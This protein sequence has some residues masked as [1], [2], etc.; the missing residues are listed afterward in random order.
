[1]KVKKPVK[2]LVMLL[3]LLLVVEY[4]VL[5][6]IPGIRH[7]LSLIADANIWL[8][9][10]GVGL[11][12]IALSAYA[13]LT[14]T[15]LP[16]ETRPRFGRIVRIDLSTLSISHIVPGGGAV[17]AGLGYRLLT[18]A[19]VGG[20]DAGFALG[21]QGIGS[22]VVLNLLL[23][24]A[25]VV[26]I[27]LHGFNPVYVTAAAVGAVLIGAFALLVLALTRGEARAAKVFRA[28]ARKLP[29]LDE[30]KV[31]RMVHRLAARIRSLLRDRR[32]LL[33]A[34]GWAA[35]NW[36]FD[37]ASLWVFLA[38]YGT[39]PGPVELMVAYGLANVLAAIPVTPGGLGVVEAVLTATLVGF[40][41]T[42]GPAILGVITY[43]LVN[44]WL[45]IPVGGLCYV[46]LA[47]ERGRRGKLREVAQ[48]TIEERQRPGEWAAEHGLARPGPPQDAAAS[49]AG[50]R[51]S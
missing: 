35:A 11:E 45:P 40:G 12:A 1:M 39:P 3:L 50:T 36:I 30:E 24:L 38:A 49:D 10:A 26:S 5:P 2:R 25:L 22:A 17:G 20:T 8:I 14:R 47:V 51:A 18:E 33:R 34:I 28:V 43:R 15:V 9:L 29:F 32:L 13:Q 31:H 41:M 23:W 42:R 6:Q 21:T 37:A 16:V 7:S 4:L 27:P 48:Q 19:G 46:S 44:F